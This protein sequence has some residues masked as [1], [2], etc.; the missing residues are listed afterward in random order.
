MRGGV[1]F[2]LLAGR[3]CHQSLERRSLLFLWQ[4]DSR[5][6]WEELMQRLKPCSLCWELVREP[7]GCDCRCIYLRNCQVVFLCSGI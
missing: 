1:V 2:R 5:V 6:Y 3:I 7:L 4:Q